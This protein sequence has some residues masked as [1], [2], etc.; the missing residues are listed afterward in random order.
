MTICSHG[1]ASK[2]EFGDQ[3]IIDGGSISGTVI[4]IAF[5][6]VGHEVRV[7]WW[8]NGALHDAWVAEWRCTK[9]LA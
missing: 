5:Y 2:F 4:G 1:Y 9:V 7:S 6:P 3:V 8:N